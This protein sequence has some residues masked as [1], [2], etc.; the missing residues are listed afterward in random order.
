MS[1]SGSEAWRRPVL[2]RPNALSIAFGLGRVFPCRT[3]KGKVA[4]Q[5]HTARFR[6]VSSLA[7]DGRQDIRD[8]HA[9]VH[10]D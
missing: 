8:Q 1:V 3:G 4:V 9:G 6:L 10:N 2:A 7:Y 5:Y